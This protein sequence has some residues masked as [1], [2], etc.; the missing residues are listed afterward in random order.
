MRGRNGFGRIQSDERPCKTPL[1]QVAKGLVLDVIHRRARRP[2]LAL[3]DIG[4][5]D[6]GEHVAGRLGGV[7]EHAGG[8]V[9]DR[10]VEQLY[11]LEHGHLGRRTG[12]PVA[13][14][15][16]TL[17]AQDARAAEVGEQLLQELDWDLAPTGELGDRYRSAISMVV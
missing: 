17:G 14:L 4:D 10:P 12:E 5:R 6:G 2:R 7:G 1:S 3:G 15:D 9:A 13:A 16:A 8:L 11:D